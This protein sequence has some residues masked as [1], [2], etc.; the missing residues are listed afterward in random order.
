MNFFVRNPKFHGTLSSIIVEVKILSIF[1]QKNAHE[2]KKN[3]Q[4]KIEE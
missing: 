1:I 2:N 3:S 4:R